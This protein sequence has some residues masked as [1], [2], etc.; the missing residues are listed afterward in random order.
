MISVYDTV[1][2]TVDETTL[3]GGILGDGQLRWAVEVPAEYDTTYNVD[4]T[5]DPNK[6]T[7]AEN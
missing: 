2:V 5:G 6:E 1:V 3:T 7:H 4:T